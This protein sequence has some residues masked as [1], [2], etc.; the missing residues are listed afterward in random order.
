M[1]KRI[2]LIILVAVMM[3]GTASL[4]IGERGQGKHKG[5]MNRQELLLQLPEEK[6]ML[7][8]K[9]MRDVRQK[10]RGIREQV[11]ALHNELKDIFV[12]PEFNEALFRKKMNDIHSLK[13][14]ARKEM[15]NAIVA[16]AEKFTSEE[17]KILVKLIPHKGKGHH[18]RTHGR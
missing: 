2:M 1:K 11:R 16:L 15:E 5:W 12:A 9:T 17:R 10:T 3:A 7:Y 8:H 6:E 14:N 13:G 18:G 4:A